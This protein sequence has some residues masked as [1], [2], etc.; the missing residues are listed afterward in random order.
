MSTSKVLEKKKNHT[1]LG[2]NKTKVQVRANNDSKGK[3]PVKN[4][5]EIKTTDIFTNLLIIS[6]ETLS[7]LGDRFYE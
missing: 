4:I 3:N 1:I 2:Y 7:D 6:S 5:N